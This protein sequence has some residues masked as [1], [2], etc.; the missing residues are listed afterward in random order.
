[1]VPR[2]SEFHVTLLVPINTQTSKKGDKITAQVLTPQAFKGDILEGRIDEAK[3][4]GKIKGKSV[5]HFTFQTLNH[6][7][8]AIPHPA[9]ARTRAAE[10]FRSGLP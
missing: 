2:D 9:H 10:F 4:G 5:L 3:S 8:R 7:G 6:A 1:M